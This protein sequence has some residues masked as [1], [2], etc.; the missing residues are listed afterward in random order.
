MESLLHN[1]IFGFCQ[2]KKNKLL[3][4]KRFVPNILCPKNKKNFSENFLLQKQVLTRLVYKEKKKNKAFLYKASTF[5]NDKALLILFKAK[6]AHGQKTKQRTLAFKNKTKQQC[7]V[8]VFFR[9]VFSSKMKKAKNKQTRSE[10]FFL[11]VKTTMLL[12]KTMKHFFVSQLSKIN[13]PMAIA[14]G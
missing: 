5:K 11:F 12:C 7:F 9:F 10:V 3:F 14:F 2:R 6:F 13:K 1:K 8:F 4:S